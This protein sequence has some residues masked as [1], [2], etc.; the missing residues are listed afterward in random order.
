M[1]VGLVDHLT[2][3]S[4][5]GFPPFRPMFYENPLPSPPK[6]LFFLHHKQ[7]IRVALLALGHVKTSVS[8]THKCPVARHCCCVS[9]ANRRSDHIPSAS[10]QSRDVALMPGCCQLNLNIPNPHHPSRKGGWV[11]LRFS[12]KKMTGINSCGIK[13]SPTF[14]ILV[15]TPHNILFDGRN[16]ANH[17]LGCY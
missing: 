7:S 17:H 1:S 14:L 15:G 9:A 11:T 5:P 13:L 12:R 16:L 2:P 4:N 6:H 10:I 3:S 8:P